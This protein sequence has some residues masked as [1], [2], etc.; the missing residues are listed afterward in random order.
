VTHSPA[1][2]PQYSP[3]SIWCPFGLSR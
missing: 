2:N 3:M 1:S